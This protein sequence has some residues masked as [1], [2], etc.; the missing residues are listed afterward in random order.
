M[1][2]RSTAG[3][4]RE[5]K[6]LRERKKAYLHC[7]C[8]ILSYWPLCFFWWRHLSISLNC[9][10]IVRGKF[11]YSCQLS[12]IIAAQVMVIINMVHALLRISAIMSNI[13]I[14]NKGRVISTI[15][16]QRP[17]MKSFYF[18]SL[19]VRVTYIHTRKYIPIIRIKVGGYRKIS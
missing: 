4:E 2:K 6:R 10:H 1:I 15:T 12:N 18:M 3:I 13:M 17:K 14:H 11:E 16:V 8:Y 5:K 19:V 9:S 7:Y